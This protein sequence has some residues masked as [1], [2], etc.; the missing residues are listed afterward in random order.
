MRRFKQFLSEAKVFLTTEMLGKVSVTHRKALR[1]FRDHIEGMGVKVFIELK[2]QG[3]PSV[4]IHNSLED[5]VDVKE[6]Q[7]RYGFPNSL[8]NCALASMAFLSSS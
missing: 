8:S 2:G 3:N 1:D 4:F 5:K 7:D 6:L